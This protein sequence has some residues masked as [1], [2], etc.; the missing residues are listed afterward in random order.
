VFPEDV[1]KTDQGLIDSKTTLPVT[2]G[3]IEKMSKSKKNIISLFDA[4][5]DYGAD[6]IRLFLLSD[7]PIERDLEWSDTGIEGAW[8]YLNRA[9]RFVDKLAQAVPADFSPNFKSLSDDALAFRKQTHI[10]IKEVTKDIEDH[11]LNKAIARL[12]AYTNLLF[13]IDM[14]DAFLSVLYEGGS[15]FIQM[16]APFAPHF[17][18][19]AWEILGHKKLVI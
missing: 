17:S 14:T 9:W 16:I 3:R 4:V 8:K 6:T 15:V 11:H 1:M 13:E 5:N 12:R 2:A 7:S 10:L 18:E 19:E